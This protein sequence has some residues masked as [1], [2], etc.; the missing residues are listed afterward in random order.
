MRVVNLVV[1]IHKTVNRC[2]DVLVVV[3]NPPPHGLAVLVVN[4]VTA[5]MCLGSIALLE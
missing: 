1:R 4:D 5:W 2:I 3:V